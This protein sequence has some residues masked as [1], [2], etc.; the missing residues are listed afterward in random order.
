MDKNIYS[1]FKFTIFMLFLLLLTQ[2][3]VI[4]MD[5][6]YKSSDI[7]N[8]NKKNTI[9][10]S[11]IMSVLLLSWCIYIIYF[12]KNDSSNDDVR[13]FTILVGIYS[14]INVVIYSLMYDK[15]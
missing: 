14:M 9:M 13:Y 2:L 15:Y 3:I 10:T 4:V 11:L 1:M 7:N 12:I 6:L 5:N 8:I